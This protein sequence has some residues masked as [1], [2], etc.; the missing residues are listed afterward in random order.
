MP[1]PG[2]GSPGIATAAPFI[3][4]MFAVVMCRLHI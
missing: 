2:A 1:A 4:K 3:A